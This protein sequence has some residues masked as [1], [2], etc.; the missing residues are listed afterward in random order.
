MA[1]SPTPAQYFPKFVGALAAAG[2]LACVLLHFAPV[3]L[4]S[5]VLPKDKIINGIPKGQTKFSLGV[6][7]K[8]KEHKALMEAEGKPK[9]IMRRE[10]P[11]S[12]VSAPKPDAWGRLMRKE[13]PLAPSAAGQA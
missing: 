9:G 10:Q 2:T 5:D 1:S 13:E 12:K 7:A 11:R 3:Q 4:A 8:L 6:A